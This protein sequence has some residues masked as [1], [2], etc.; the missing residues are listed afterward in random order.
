MLM[1]VTSERGGLRVIV[2]S[3]FMLLCIFPLSAANMYCL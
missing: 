1:A 3:Y 2:I